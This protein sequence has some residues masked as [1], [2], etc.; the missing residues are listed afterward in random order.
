[1]VISRSHG[2]ADALMSPRWEVAGHNAYAV[3]VR[4]TSLLAGEQQ[5]ERGSLP[6]QSLTRVPHA[7]VQA[8]PVA[9]P[10]SACLFHLR[11]EANTAQ[12]LG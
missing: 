6:A 3:C 1:M 4:Y 5:I 2:N 8:A 9:K 7:P 10:A 12:A 11:S